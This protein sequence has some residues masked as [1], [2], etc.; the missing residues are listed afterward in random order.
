MTSRSPPPFPRLFPRHTYRGG[1]VRRGHPPKPGDTGTGPHGP[2][3]DHG[4]VE[5]GRVDVDH[6]KGGGGPHLPDDGQNQRQYG[7][8]CV[9]RQKSR[10]KI[11][12]V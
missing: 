3:A 9:Q 4:G 10:I 11:N 8:L 5:L 7:Q 6:P 12:T 1:Y 2:I